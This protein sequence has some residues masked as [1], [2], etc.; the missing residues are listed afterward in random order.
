[1]KFCTAYISD[2]LY[3]DEI[4]SYDL[5]IVPQDNRQ[6]AI[7]WRNAIKVANPNIIMLGYIQVISESFDK[8]DGHNV[9]RTLVDKD[10]FSIVDN[11]MPLYNY[12]QY[13]ARRLYDPRKPAWSKA[14]LRACEATMFNYPF[15]GLFLDN[16]TIFNIHNP[17]KLVRAD[18]ESALQETL[19]DLRRIFPTT[20]IVGNCRDNWSGLNGEMNEGRLSDADSELPP[21]V[22]QT[23]P[24]MNLLQYL[25]SDV[26]EQQAY[27]DKA[28]EHNAYFGAS[29]NFQTVV[30]SSLI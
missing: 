18:M 1:M 10:A 16:C 20:P 13:G 17:D 27:K 26:T 22:G 12:T 24:N 5:C 21:Y 7:D 29:V 11:A 25:G 6:P 14:F 23:Q 4:A 19:L 9:M 3:V 30:N 28:I 15:D 2:G 8:G